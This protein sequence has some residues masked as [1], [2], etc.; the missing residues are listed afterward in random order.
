MNKKNK[1]IILSLLPSLLFAMNDENGPSQES[2]DYAK[3]VLTELGLPLPG[4]GIHIIPRSLMSLPPEAI[5]EHNKIDAQMKTQGFV[6]ENTTRPTELLNFKDHAKTEFAMYNHNDS[7]RGTHLRHSVSELKMAYIFKGVPKSE[8]THYIGIAPQGS[9]HNEGWSG[10]GQFFDNKHV[11]SCA[12]GEMSVKVTNTAVTL[13]ME[14][15][16]YEVNNKPTVMYVIGNKNSG[17]LYKIRWFDDDYFRE[18]ECANMNYSANITKKF[19][20]LAQRIDSN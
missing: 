18:L 10:A 2:Q 8:M 9:Y 3:K 16:S 7:D 15:V 14:G 12:Y 11:G 19:I 17:Y 5:E 1:V 20:E 6:K 4:S 13:A